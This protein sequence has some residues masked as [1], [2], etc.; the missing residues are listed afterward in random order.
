MLRGVRWASD[1]SSDRS[2]STVSE[3]LFATIDTSRSHAPAVRPSRPAHSLRTIFH[4]V[5]NSLTFLYIRC[6][7]DAYPAYSLSPDPDTQ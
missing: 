1:P 7:L 4:D 5:T 2:G 6:D 3:Q